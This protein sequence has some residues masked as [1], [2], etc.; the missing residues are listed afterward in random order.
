MTKL[1]HIIV[2]FLCGFGV[3]TAT[4]AL[5]Q[6]SYGSLDGYC[7]YLRTPGHW[8]DMGAKPFAYL[9]VYTVAVGI[10]LLESRKSREK[11]K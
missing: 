2:S 7:A 6:D 9:A 11:Q 4:N 1:E 8:V 5:H 10:V 3:A